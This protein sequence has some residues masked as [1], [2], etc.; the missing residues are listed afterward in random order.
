M[1]TS[2]R[3]QGPITANARGF[4]YLVFV[5]VS[6][7]AAAVACGGSDITT[8]QATL[9]VAL[10]GSG[11]GTV[12]SSV[13]GINCTNGSGSASGTCQT[14]VNTGTQVTL[15]ANAAAGSSFGG[16]S[17]DGVSC[18]ASAPCTI[19]V[20]SDR[21]ITATFNGAA[22]TQVLTVVGGGSGTGSGHV[23]SDLPGIDCA[24][25]SGDAGATGCSAEFSTGATVQLQVQSGNLVAW[26]G[27]CSGT[28]CSVTMTEAQTVI[29]TFGVE[30]QATQ[31]VFVGQPSGVQL[32][33]VI[34]PPVQVAIEDATGQIVATRT[35]PIT[36]Q[37]GANPGNAS[38]AGTVTKNA[39]NGVA[40][41]SDLTLN[42]VGDNYTL[43]A[44]TPQLPNAPSA[45]FNV[46]AVPVAHL[47]FSVQPSNTQA[48]AAITP[49]VVVQIQDQTNTV[50]T[51]RTDVITISLQNNPGNGSVSGTVTAT[52]VAGI[53]T[54]PNLI[55]TKAANGYT[56]TA[57][58]GNASGVVSTAFNVAPGS[59]AQLVSNAAA[60]RNAFAGT[61]V[62]Q[63][64]RP[65][66]K[67]LDAF[68]N[69][70]PNISVN[71]AVTAGG[72]QVDPAS[73]TTGPMG[74]SIVISWTLGPDVGT[75]NNELQ[76]SLAGVNGSP[77]IFKAS[78]KLPT[79]DGLFSGTLKTISNTG[80]FG[81]PI[82]NA[83]VV[84]KTLPNE[85]VVGTTTTRADGS[86]TSPPIP[87]GNQY[88]IEVNAATFK[89][90]TF[91]K[92]GLDAGATFSLGNLGMVGGSQEQGQ[93]SIGFRVDLADKPS[94]SRTVRVEVYK[95]FY[96]GASDEGGSCEGSDCSEGTANILQQDTDV[97]TDVSNNVVSNGADMFISPLGD[98]GPLTV[99]V[100]VV[101]NGG[102][103]YQ[104]QDRL[105]VLDNPMAEVQ[106]C[107]EV[108][109]QQPCNDPF[110]LNPVQ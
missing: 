100:R 110:D 7:A 107:D 101:D 43:V 52:A 63:G 39:V 106:S 35:D 79:G 77:V 87:G 1:L 66:V 3:T 69:P 88:K 62:A 22:A 5:L 99:R 78:G 17:G 8:P 49:A 2:S 96:V 109:G 38:L 46:S 75:D 25:T 85:G 53:A 27:A 94:G 28:T 73:R 15:S 9:T 21:T 68:N 80:V 58:T 44:S 54:F 102:T 14:G 32:G 24:I 23:V 48:G 33:N 59:P 30:A 61:A 29:A 74:V 71:W 108:S 82:A 41:F 98:W 45:P 84:F 36:L 4:G 92:P 81:N 37:I 103:A 60:T 56:L 93:A 19:T 10:A 83:A 70:V 55:L 89:P 6:A 31:L 57:A 67:V 86:F 18:D 47:V 40:T 50:L 65:S 64:D 72:G 76:A 97:I 51:S 13:G 34:A 105:V 104:S 91:Q 42:Q 12:T 11:N 95:G 20:Q 26:G 90:V 16:W